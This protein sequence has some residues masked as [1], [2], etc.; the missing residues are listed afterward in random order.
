MEAAAHRAGLSLEPFEFSVE[1]IP[2]LLDTTQPILIDH[3]D[4]VLLLGEA[5]MT[6]ARLRDELFAAPLRE[7]GL[8]A[9]TIL[10]RAGLSGSARERALA[11]LSVELMGPE[12]CRAWRVE[13]PPSAPWLTILRSGPWLRIAAGLTVAH[14]ARLG[15]YLLSWWVLGL[16]LLQGHAEPGWLGAWA[17]LLATSVPLQVCATWLQGR[18][19][20]A[21][22]GLFKRRLLEGAFRL[23]SEEVSGEGAG[24][25]LGRMFEADS[26]ET[27]VL[28]GG[29]SALVGILEAAAAVALLLLAGVPVLAALLVAWILVGIGLGVAFYRAARVWTRTRLDITNRLVE[30]MVGYVTRFV[31]EDPAHWHDAE[32]RELAE[33]LEVSRRRDRA[34]VRLLAVLGRGWLLLA[35]LALAPAVLRTASPALIAG[36]L[37]A[38]M[39]ASQALRRLAVS[40]WQLADAAIAREQVLPLLRAAV[41][42]ENAGAGI[43]LPPSPCLEA[44]GIAYAYQGASEPVLRGCSATIAPGARILLEGGSGGGKSTFAA[45]L[46]GLRTPLS[47]FLALGGFDRATLGDQSWRRHVSLAP[48]FHQNHVITGPLSFNLLMGRGTLLQ[49][50]DVEEALQICREL[51]LAPLLDRMPGGIHQLVGDTGWQLSQGERSRVYIARALLQKPSVV[52]LD[53]SLGT[54]DP[55]TLLEAIATIERRAPA[56]LLIAHP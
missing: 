32:D 17:L 48:Q 26:L 52:I 13:V 37:G 27:L 39:L 55:H 21:T 24:G 19:A 22:A 40:A 38:V 56:V 4:G 46:A 53:E 18:L 34:E 5:R 51:G 36:A 54:L 41:R 25:F 50:E 28:S 6:A 30:R 16:V 2:G 45:L 33:Y 10:D 14:I 29:V 12:R 49:K 47:G 11:A 7:A 23:E 3:A 15:V 43:L 42:N 31:Q 8:R 35:L 44:D 9:K 1:D 20:V